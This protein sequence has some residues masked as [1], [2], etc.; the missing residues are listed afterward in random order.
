[1]K[2]TNWLKI[3]AAALILAFI[4]AACPLPNDTDNTGSEIESINWVIDN[5]DTSFS[6]SIPYSA[7]IQFFINFETPGPTAS[8]IASVHIE[9]LI[10]NRSWIFDDP[11]ENAKLYDAERNYFWCRLVSTSFTYNGSVLPVG[12]YN[13]TVTYSNGSVAKSSFLVP[14][15][16]ATVIGSTS[17]VYTED[18]MAASNPPSDYA[19]LPRRANNISAVRSAT[20]LTI[21]FSVNDGKIYNSK[22]WFYDSE[23]AYI[24][25]TGWFRDFS[26][27][28]V[29]SALNDGKLHNDGTENTLVLLE[30]DIQFA[31]GKGMTD[32][33]SLSI[34][35]TDGFQYASN[36]RTYDT[37][38]ISQKVDVVTTGIEIESINWGID[39]IDSSFSESIP[40]SA[41]IQFFIEF[42]TPGPA[43]SDI[44][45]VYIESPIRDISW[46]FANPAQIT[47]LYDAEGNY[48]WCRLFSDFP[49]ANGSVLP[50]GTYN[51]TVR[52]S[53]GSVAKSSLLV[54]APGAIETG[55]TLYV[56][57]EDYMAASNPPSI[58]AALP[59]R[60][61]NISAVRLA[62]ELTIKF[63]VNDGNIYNSKV[64]F[65]DSEEA[66]VGTTDWFR[67][68]SIGSVSSA[69]NNG[70]LHN[71]G[72]ENTLVLPE[73]DIQFDE[74]K[75]MSDIYSLFIILTDGFQYASN[76]SPYDTR[77]VS[78]E[79]FVGTN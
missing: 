14:A 11:A 59:R 4:L 37:A 6:E 13:F 16:G 22:V 27:G 24:G 67:D 39:N 23:Q 1:M 17:Y 28:S 44:A 41:S 61:N 76:D 75:G 73:S 29:S 64:T 34:F 30:S 18:Y 9:S 5:I 2:T 45:S 21:K 47:A 62:S 10:G 38:S 46:V 15:P 53:N 8:D 55:S 71:D 60:A 68:F 40:Y 56:Y 63:S 26:T 70:K 31:E 20:E 57:T 52:Y 25:P 79:V 66:Y 78:Q 33:D 7:S 48:F 19:A 32:I 36:D 69:L 12:T 54:P 72:T 42:E 51:F 35:L 74:G 58:Y 65:Y 43:A 49:S 50:V 77:S 3:A